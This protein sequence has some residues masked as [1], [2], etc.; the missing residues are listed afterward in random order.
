MAAGAVVRD[1]V[2]WSDVDRARIVYFGKYLRWI[3]AAE[4]EFFRACGFSY[5][6]IEDELGIFLARVH[7]SMDFRRPARLDDELDCSAALERVG[8]SSLHFRYR[9]ERGA[10]RIADVVLVLACLD[11]ATMRPVRVPPVLAASVG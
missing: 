7:L 10:E 5:D 6:R 1:R 4:S 8:G 9:I 2:H 3:E 11:R